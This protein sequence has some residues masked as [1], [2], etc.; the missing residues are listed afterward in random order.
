VGDGGALVGINYKHP[1]LTRSQFFKTP[2]KT[3]SHT[4]RGKLLTEMEGV[5]MEGAAGSGWYIE[6]H[7]QIEP[8][9]I[10]IELAFSEYIETLGSLVAPMAAQKIAEIYEAGGKPKWIPNTPSWRRFKKESGYDP[11]T[12]H[13]T[14]KLEERVAELSAH[15]RSWYDDNSG[16][17]FFNGLD[18]GFRGAEYVWIHEFL[19]IPRGQSRGVQNMV[20]RPFIMQ[21]LLMALQA[22]ASADVDA[23]QT[24][25]ERI[26]DGV[27]SI[28]IEVVSGPVTPPPV[29][30]QYLWHETSLHISLISLLWWIIPPSKMLMVFGAAMDAI[31]VVEGKLLKPRY[32]SLW[33]TAYVKGQVSARAG[34]FATEKQ[35]RRKGRR[36]IY[37]GRG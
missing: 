18:E 29:E 33:V 20:R 24:A 6:Y 37:R 12:M 32:L 35:A 3:P 22:F 36:Y 30:N 7:D 17:L 19:G 25:V 4:I 9:V 21:G 28:N 31:S 34:L 23:I 2:G 27:T 16:V 26:P 1:G 15:L 11:R 13:M 10:A 8:S 5:H 14:G